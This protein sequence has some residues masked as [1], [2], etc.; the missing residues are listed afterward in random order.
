MSK[1]K[2][3]AKGHAWVTFV[4]WLA[5]SK[6]GQVKPTDGEVEPCPFFHVQDP[7]VKEIRMKEE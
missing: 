7:G 6:C 2:E 1:Q 5:C 3:G 4:F